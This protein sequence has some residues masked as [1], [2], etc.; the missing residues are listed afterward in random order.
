[1]ITASAML[2]AMYNHFTLG[3]LCLTTSFMSCSN[4]PISAK[5]NNFRLGVLFEILY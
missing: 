2:G 4:L 1:M 3:V 5:N